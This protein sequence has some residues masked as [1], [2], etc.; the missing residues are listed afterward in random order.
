M[1]SMSD[2]DPALIT[3]RYSDGAS[4]AVR[5]VVVV[6]VLG[7]LSLRDRDEDREIARWPRDRILLL[8]DVGGGGAR[9]GLA[10]ARLTVDDLD[11][12]VA[13]RGAVPEIFTAT[14]PE[15]RPSAGLLVVAI[16]AIGGLIGTYFALPSVS[17]VL[18]PLVP[19]SWYDKVGAA[20]ADQIATVFGG[21][22]DGYCHDEAGDAAL[23]DLMA[24]LAAT[25]ETPTPVTVRI[26]D[27]GMV[28]AFAAPGGHLV[29]MRGLIDFVEAPSELVG[30]LAHEYAHARG[31][32]PESGLFHAVIGSVLTRVA[33]GGSGDVTSQIGFVGGTLLDLSHSR[34]VEAAADALALEMLSA[35]GLRTDGLAL[36]FERLEGE[37]ED[38]DIDLPGFL[39]SH[40]N[41]AARAAASNAAR[42]G[43]D[44][45]LSKAQWDAVQAMCAS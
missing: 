1:L 32:D 36:F 11:G 26:I 5:T 10:D 15:R 20:A 35:A 7:G 8:D 22:E 4:A 31:G 12:A 19:H 43:Q 16:A 17:D 40:P 21:G 24:R 34:D 33:L 42:G 6:P 2:S 29:V 25:T 13:L 23:R 38:Q 41:S 44:R 18:A 30:V 37:S 28:N 3:G 39:S 9:F 45:G 27:G 14:P